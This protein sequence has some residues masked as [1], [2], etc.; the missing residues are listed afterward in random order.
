MPTP[1]P[2]QIKRSQRCMQVIVEAIEKQHG[3]ISFE[4]YMQLCLYSEKLGYYESGTD[5]FGAD[6]DFTTS[7]ERSVYFA[8]AFAAYIQRLQKTLPNLCVVEIGA[9]SG[10]FANDL[11]TR[12]QQLKCLPKQYIIVEKSA[13]L[14]ARQQHNLAQ[15]KDTCEIVWLQ[16]PT[17]LIENA[18]VIANEVVDAL[19]VRL[20][21]IRNNQ[22]NERY[23]C[24]DGSGV[25]EFCD[26]LANEYLE[27]LVR[28]RIPQQLLNQ[29][30]HTY[31][32]DI[33]LQLDNFV[34]QIASFVKQGIFFYIDYGYPRREYYHEQRHMGTLVCHFKH[35]TNEQPLL[36][37][38]LQDI[39]C[40]VDFTALA[41]AADKAKLHID[42]YTTQAH[43]LLASQL[44]ENVTFDDQ[45][46]TLNQHSELKK[47]LMP[48]EMGERFQVMVLSK[49][50]D[51]S[52]HQFTTRDLLHRL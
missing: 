36:W 10:K 34:E 5:I 15:H 21:A 25:L 41:E 35:T 49:N 6:G 43:F 3:A 30:T 28:E 24:V 38:G 8:T 26:Y 16:Q 19:P 50:L 47:L 23:V 42:C 7:P 45:L 11:I 27:K 37:P 52:G 40:N 12:L 22:I 44:L 46:T 13:A 29:D 1:T 2:Q 4:H 9:G 32:A 18:V 51:L 48:G 31:R 20:L 14:R 17:Q 39:S 33:N